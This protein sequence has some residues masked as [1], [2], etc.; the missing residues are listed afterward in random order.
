MDF[1]DYK[2]KL[3]LFNSS[4]KYLNEMGFLS[5]IMDL[6]SNDNILDFGCGIGT[7][8]TYL[9]RKYNIKIDGYDVYNYT[10]ELPN[11]YIN[12]LMKSY[13]KVTFFHSLAHISDTTNMFIFLKKHLKEKSYIYIITP[14][15]EFD[16]IFKIK[17]DKI[18]Y[19][20]DYTVIK[21]FHQ[22]ELLELLT[23]NGFKIIN[24]GSFGKIVNKINERL[25][26]IAQN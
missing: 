1:K 3:E 26:I 16:D 22:E 23:K 7:F 18:E 4:E 15:K 25:F 12:K 9:E 21:H 8:M 14:N 5:S 11:I 10:N 19:K 17:F 20:P 13:N 6:N 24:N 2:R